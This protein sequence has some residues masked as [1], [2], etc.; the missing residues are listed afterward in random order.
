[1]NIDTATS[2]TYLLAPEDAG[3]VIRVVVNGV[4]A[5]YEGQPVT[6][7]PTVSV[8]NA[9]FTSTP[10]P[11]ISG[12]VR[13]GVTVSAVTSAWTPVA[14]SS[15]FVWKRNGTAIAGATGP[16]YEIAAADLGATLSFVQTGSALGYSATP[17]PSASTVAVVK[18]IFSTLPTPQVTG[19]AKIG[20]TLTASSALWQPAATLTYQW[21]RAGQ[22]ISGATSSTYVIQPIDGGSRIAVSVTASKTAYDSV[23][24]VSNETA[25]V[26]YLAFTDT[27]LPAIS[28]TEK[29]EGVLTASTGDWTPT[30]TTFTYQWKRTVSSVTTS[31]D[32]AT[33]ATYTLVGEDAGATIT[34]AVTGTKLGY[35]PVTQTSEPSEVIAY[36]TLSLTPSPTINGVPQ[37]GVAYGL[38]AGT[39]SPLPVQLTYQWFLE[40]AEITGA[41]NATYTPIAGDVGGRLSVRVT[42]SK[43]GYDSVSRT[44]A[45]TVAIILG[46][47]SAPAPT[48]AGTAKVGSALTATP[49]TWT[50]ATSPGRT[51]Q[52]KKSVSG[53][54]TN[55]SGETGLTYTLVAA[56]V[57]AT[58]SFTVSGGLDGYVSL[59]KI[60]AA[61][62]AVVKGTFSSPPTPLISGTTTP[63]RVGQQLGV[64]VGH[65]T[66]QETGVTYQWKRDG[67]AISGATGS[68]Y[69]TQAA[70]LNKSVT[71]TATA[72][73]AGYVDGSSTSAARV[74]SAGIFGTSST[75]TISGSMAVG[76]T[77][78]ADPG[79]WAP[80]ATFA[81]Q[82]K[83]AGTAISGA[84]AS[85]YVLRPED[86]DK[87]LS[88]VVTGSRAGYTSI[89]LPS[90]DT[91][92]VARIAFTA[93]PEPVI[94]GTAA[95]GQ[96]LTASAGTW[97]PSSAASPI[98]LSYRWE[99]GG[100]TIVGATSST[101]LVLPGD[102]TSK[103][104][105]YVTGTK[106][107]Y[108][109]QE[110]PSA[111]TSAVVKGTLTT[112][113]KPTITGTAQVGVQLTAVAGTWQPTAAAS[114]ITYTYRWKSDGTDI[115]GATSATYTPVV[116]DL[117]KA[118]SVAVT[119]AKT[120]F[121]SV[122]QTSDAVAP[123]LVTIAG[124]FGT[125]PR[126]TITG[127]ATAKVGV[128][129]TAVVGTWVPA[130]GSLAYQ[131]KRT[132]GT[133]TT[134]I[135]GGTSSRYT[136]TADD[137]GKT[138]SVV[139]TAT[140]TGYATTA[141]QASL[142]TAAVALGTFATPSTLPAISGTV[143]VNETLSAS[144]GSTWPAGV[145]LSYKWNRNG[146]AISAAQAATYRLVTAD[147]GARITVT[148]TGIVTG[149]AAQSITSTQTIAVVASA[150]GAPT[151][152]TSSSVTSSSVAVR[153]T[154]PTDTGGSAITDYKV[155]YSS[156]GGSTWNVFAHVASTATSITVTGLTTATSHKIRVSTKN[157]IGFSTPSTVLTVTTL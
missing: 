134:N 152:L 33:R 110:Q 136:P 37:V 77:L 91:A 42:G 62:L 86:A 123:R 108:I 5:G 49:G 3:R 137:Q 26:E 129:L 46:V 39:W 72:T 95:V 127:G 9:T 128:E 90:A 98:A 144:T 153:W 43:L 14:T 107:G 60:S 97:T 16:T 103:I 69:D 45:K 106:L 7:Q 109:T 30:P 89:S 145:S 18:G 63:S 82:W 21:Q 79:S 101:Y 54:T 44:S 81:Y 41:T 85:T 59:T 78:T 58:I 75:P 1:V 32:G 52:W 83:R 2:S 25:A 142:A 140:T 147:V 125:I 157:A 57:G 94:S 66:P 93:A 114:P 40:D 84:T 74:I 87:V 138:L 64:S 53:V 23:T 113:P 100:N 15:T 130:A 34:V 88:V 151:A 65:W 156:D 48:I 6:S 126:P 4:R 12:T 116:A 56:D 61:T 35:A 115:S 96:T 20:L 17:I 38:G 19:R 105:V 50:P 124:T 55:I 102:E 133:S 80:V 121:T 28:G 143:Q 155:E 141:S 22:N 111:E 117:G 27:V 71:V 119:G 149:Y 150:P 104:R 92:T 148:V 146:V 118:I 47:F 135:S 11:T 51:Y 76:A 139:V 24:K 68:T 122:T 112:T 99:K 131:W 36:G 10:V 120:G 73:L 67:V 154:A 29:V 70:D 13:V 132:S 31:I 8:A